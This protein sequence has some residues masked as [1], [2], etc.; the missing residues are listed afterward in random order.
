MRYFILFSVII[1]LFSSCAE[2]ETQ[3]QSIA[4]KYDISPYLTGLDSMGY[5]I[6]NDTLLFQIGYQNNYYGKFERG[7]ALIEYALS[8][9]DTI[10]EDDYH[11]WSVLNSKNG[12]YAIAIDKLEKMMK[13]NPEEGSAYYG[14][15]LL[16][17]Y[18]DYEKALPILEQYD[19]LTPDFSDAP[20]GEDIHY[21]KGL[22]HM[23]LGRYQKAIDEFDTYIN[24][25]ATTHGEDFVDVYT[26]VQKGRC[27]TK[28][29]RFEEAIPSYK[30]AIKYYEKCSEA[31]YFMGLTQLEMKDN[32]KACSNFNIALDLINKGNK[33]SDNYLEYFHEIYPQQIEI[34]ISESCQN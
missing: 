17:Y 29:G 10:T 30:K 15:L 24:N 5:D 1:L 28:L 25:L 9:R 23:Q 21:L 22:C 3:A 19:A 7:N 4:E 34:S 13:L 12:N 32:D 16:Y 6:A 20:M 14:W 26:F 33:S 18:R 2:N 11:G 27:L 31:Y 8:K